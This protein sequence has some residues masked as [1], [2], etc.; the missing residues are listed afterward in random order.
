ME[1]YIRKY[2]GVLPALVVVVC[3]YLGATAANHIIEAKALRDSDKLGKA[4]KVVKRTKGKVLPAKSKDGEAIVARNMFCSTCIPAEPE[5]AEAGEVIDS[6]SPPMTSLPLRLVATNVST[7]SAY[8]FAMIQNTSTDRQGSYSIEQKIPESGAVVR[9]S[10]KYVDFENEKSKRVERLSL[11]S[12]K[13]APRKKTETKTKTKGKGK[14]G[15]NGELMAMVEEGV[16]KVSDTEFEID[17]KVVDKILENPMSVARGARI[18]PSVKHGKA[19]GFKLYAIRPSSVYAKIGLM[20][21]DTIH[22]INGFELTSPDKA[23]EVYTKV[24]SAS[25]LS[26]NA[27]RRGKPISLNY[28]IK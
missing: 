22:S 18:V 13:A 7:E 15:K 14:G 28:S 17:K 16:N 21:G 5:A 2:F 3:A 1:A 19:N 24:R 8:S 12:A 11:L 9:I 25:S 4:E 26:V 6:D 27:T 23:L 20:N 10:A